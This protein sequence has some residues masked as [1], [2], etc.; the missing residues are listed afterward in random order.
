M[1]LL[2]TFIGHFSQVVWKD[3]QEA[4]FGLATAK[5][6]KMYVVGQYRPPANYMNQWHKNVLPTKDG[7]ITVPS[8]E[9]ISELN[10]VSSF[11]WAFFIYRLQ[12]HFEEVA[13]LFEWHFLWDKRCDMR[14]VWHM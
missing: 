1:I 12:R 6:G 4:G 9:K 8:E 14:S 2:I 10:F 7:K 13:F 3:T 11:I 5:S